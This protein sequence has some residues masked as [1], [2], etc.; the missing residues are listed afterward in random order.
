[1]L[2]VIRIRAENE[3]YKQAKVAAFEAWDNRLKAAKAPIEEKWAEYYSKVKASRA[4]R[5]NLIQ[6]ANDICN[7]AVAPLAL[8]LKSDVDAL[9]E[10]PLSG[11]RFS[12]E[13]ELWWTYQHARTALSRTFGNEA[14]VYE[15]VQR[16]SVEDARSL[17]RQAVWQW[18]K[19]L[20]AAIKPLKVK[21]YKVFREGS[22]KVDRSQFDLKS[23]V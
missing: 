2:R 3:R 8:K 15:D 7:E 5:D 17:H 19:E 16:E 13:S 21:A 1:M 6:E 9:G 11:P 18:R 12:K 10:E 14:G 23:R 22:E 20:Y 4:T